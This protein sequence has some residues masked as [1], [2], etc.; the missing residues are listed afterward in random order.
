MTTCA[1]SESAPPRSE[2]GDDLGGGAHDRR[3][4]VD[5]RVARDHPDVLG[6][7]D[8]QSAKNFSLTSAL[9]GAV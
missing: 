7:E 4:G 9:I 3:V 1:I 6:A 8:S 5:G 2:V